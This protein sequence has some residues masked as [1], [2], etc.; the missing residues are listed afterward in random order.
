MVALILILCPLAETWAATLGRIL[1]PVE[2][3]E[4]GLISNKEAGDFFK[5][6]NECRPVA[7]GVH[8]QSEDEADKI[9]LTKEDIET[10]VRSRLRGARIFV[11]DPNLRAQPT[12]RA[13][14]LGV[15]VYLH[16][17]LIYWHARFEKVSKDMASGIVGFTATGWERFSFGGHGNEG[18]SILYDIAPV[19]DEFIDDY[20][21]VNE[22]ECGS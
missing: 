15:R 8:L 6:W 4:A 12:T 22:S 7:F 19:I 11:D 17:D 9:G 20:L 14:F 16:S 21:R 13:G 18:S 3:L 10:L 5:L 2:L 1:T